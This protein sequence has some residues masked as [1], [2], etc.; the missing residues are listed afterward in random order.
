MSKRVAN[1]RS[2][3]KARNT[4][5]RLGWRRIQQNNNKMSAMESAVANRKYDIEDNR[6]WWQ[7]TVQTIKNAFKRR[8][9]Y[10]KGRS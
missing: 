6:T 1:S 9:R 7:K 10:G 8:P 5:S 2:K 3:T 4:R